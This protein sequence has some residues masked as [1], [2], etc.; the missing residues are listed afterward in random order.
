MY[1]GALGCYENMATVEKNYKKFLNDNK[2]LP[3]Q[4]NLF[5]YIDDMI[6]ERCPEYPKE[7]L[8]EKE[9]E[10]T[11]IYISGHP[12]DEFNDVLNSCTT[13]EQILE[14]RKGTFVKT[15]GSIKDIRQVT[16]KKGDPMAFVLVETLDGEF[17]VIAFPETF[18]NA[19]HLLTVG[20]IIAIDGRTDNGKVIAKQIY[21]I[22]LL[23]QHD[24]TLWI[25]GKPNDDIL[26]LLRQFPGNDRVIFCYDGKPHKWNFGVRKGNLLIIK[27]GLLIGKENVK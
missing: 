16:T 6:M 5:S 15:A 23:K 14:S 20:A 25:N 11:G 1:S 21:P 13:A 22:S 17:E 3:G 27:I 4:M 24:P 19:F 18:S 2:S 8:L 26:S 12:L 9:K 10:Y 7:Y